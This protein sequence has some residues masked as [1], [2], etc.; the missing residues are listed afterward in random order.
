MWHRPALRKSGEAPHVGTSHELVLL[1]RDQ[2]G[3]GK[4]TGIHLRGARGDEEEEIPLVALRVTQHQGP[5]TIGRGGQRS[6]ADFH[7]LQEIQHAPGR[8]AQ[9]RHAEEPIA[10]VGLARGGRRGEQTRS[11]QDERC[12]D[13]GIA[14]V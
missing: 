10:A 1:P 14:E 6:D 9:E 13:L 5:A 11:R 12:Q 3:R 4:E 7:V 8:R 2:L